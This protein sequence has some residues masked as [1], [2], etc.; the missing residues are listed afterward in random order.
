[1]LLVG[2]DG[3]LEKRRMT[4]Y[5][6]APSSEREV[7]DFFFFNFPGDDKKKRRKCARNRDTL[8]AIKTVLPF[9]IAPTIEVLLRLLDVTS[10]T[11]AE[12]DIAGFWL[13]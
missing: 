1:M 6:Y 3:R 2:A 12:S 9:D 10:R 4:V 11:R 13:R 7:W 5:R 8:N